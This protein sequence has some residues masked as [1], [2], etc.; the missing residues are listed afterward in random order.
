MK[1]NSGFSRRLR[2]SRKLARLTY[3]ALAQLA[4]ITNS[5]AWELE[6]KPAVRPSADLVFR[7]AKALETTPQYLWLGDTSDHN[8][9]V[10]MTKYR[11]LSAANQA[12]AMKLISVL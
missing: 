3:E 4:G 6:N 10:L 1:E 8:E 12:I 9:D 2:Q 5:Y 11:S 7:L